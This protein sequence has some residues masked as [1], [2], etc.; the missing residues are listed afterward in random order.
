MDLFQNISLF[1]GTVAGYKKIF[2]SAFFL[3]LSCD[4]FLV[5]SC[6]DSEAA[7]PL[8]GNVSGSCIWQALASYEELQPWNP[9]FSNHIAKS[10]LVRIMGRFEKSGVKHSMH[11][12]QGN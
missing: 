4:M 12:S 1:L 5:H 3:D 7:T 9:D 8:L 10:T 6:I 2:F 11:P